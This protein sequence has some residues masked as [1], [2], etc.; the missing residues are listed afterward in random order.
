MKKIIMSDKILY[1][2]YVILMANIV[3]FFFSWW[4][5]Y[6]I[7]YL[8]C[9]ANML[10]WRLLIALYFLFLVCL[11]YLLGHLLVKKKKY[12]IGRGLWLLIVVMLLAGINL[13]RLTTFFLFGIY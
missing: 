1:F 4:R 8:F 2:L 7:F 6:F 11:G 10:K 12:F 13:Y 5:F 9:G 3:F